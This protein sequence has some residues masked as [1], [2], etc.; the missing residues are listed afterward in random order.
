M[1][2]VATATGLR[3][4]ALFL[5]VFLAV[6][7]PT[8]THCDNYNGGVIC[9]HCVAKSRQLELI[10]GAFIARL[11]GAALVVGPVCAM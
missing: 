6:S 11:V 7:A 1:A 10:L 3:P 5:P 4:R 2:I 9:R 8:F